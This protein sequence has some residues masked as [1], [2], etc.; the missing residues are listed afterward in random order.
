MAINGLDQARLEARIASM[1]RHAYLARS[2]ASAVSQHQLATELDSILNWLSS[3]QTWLLFPRGSTY[4]PL[5]NYL[6][7]QAPLFVSE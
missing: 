6:M 1:H 2:S 5:C 7:V 4:K 3:T